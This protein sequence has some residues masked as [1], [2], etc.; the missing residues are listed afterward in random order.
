LIRAAKYKTH[1]GFLRGVFIKTVAPGGVLWF[2]SGLSRH[3]IAGGG[4]N[5]AVE[6]GD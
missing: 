2:T 1:R 5:P 3:G 6:S 4:M